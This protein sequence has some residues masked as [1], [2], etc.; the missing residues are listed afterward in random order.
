MVVVMAVGGKV[1]A[2]KVLR[3]VEGRWD[4]RGRRWEE[5]RVS[6]REWRRRG[7]GTSRGGR[8]PAVTFIS[9]DESW[10]GQAD[11]RHGSR[12]LYVSICLYDGICVKGEN[13]CWPS[14]KFQLS[15]PN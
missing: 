7:S 4:P 14:S 9:F 6:R 5:D 12:T 13:R 10:V 11:P 3:V 15:P 1:W 2:R 8:G